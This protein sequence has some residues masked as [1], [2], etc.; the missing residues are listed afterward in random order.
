MAD[1]LDDATVL[2]IITEKDKCLTT[3]KLFKALVG[4]RI[5]I[6][7]SKWVSHSL[8]EGV[9]LNK[10][11]YM[12]RNTLVYGDVSRTENYQPFT[13]QIS[14]GTYTDLSVDDVRS[15]LNGICGTEVLIRTK[16]TII[17]RGDDE[18]IFSGTP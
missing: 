12:V 14:G 13:Y 9:L 6:V 1:S 5:T 16:E 4:R 3:L 11:D 17:I 2:I 10:L 18:L 15:L 7:S 8:R